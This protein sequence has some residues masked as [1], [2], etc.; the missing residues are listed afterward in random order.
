[1]SSGLRIVVTGL[2]GLYPVGGVAWDY[3]QYVIGL[4]R[5]GHDVFYHEDTWSWPYHPVERTRTAEGTYSARFIADFFACYAPDLQ[6]RWHYL[7]LHE[8]SFGMERATFDEVARTAD[9]FINVSGACMIPED[10]SPRCVKVFIDSDPGYNQILLSERFAWSENVERWCSAVAQHDCFFT[11]AENIHAADC[12]VPKLNF[13]WKTTRMPVVVDLWD[14]AR[15]ASPRETASWTTVMSWDD[16]Q[17]PLVYRGVE[18]RGK[19]PEFEKL[20]DLPRR[21][22]LPFRVAVGG[23]KAPLERLR[24]HGWSVIDGPRATATAEDYRSF[25]RSSRGEI[26]SAKNVYVALRTGW[27]S[28]RSACYLAAGRPVVVQDTG[29]SSRFPVGEGLLA[30]TNADEATAALRQVEMKPEQHAAAALAIA[31]E[32]FES[33]S[34]LHRLLEDAASCD[35]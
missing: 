25:V 7:H 11:Y 8:T 32:C 20:L 3:L 29:F 18:Y 22:G 5:L 30:F 14:G 1:M 2:V 26:S 28:C 31:R 23:A 9:L 6:D 15:P 17:G 4:S 16:F 21:T 13:P 10:L 35:A 12:L 33:G 24:H 27:F 34:V 19:G